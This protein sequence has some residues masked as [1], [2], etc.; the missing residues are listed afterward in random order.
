M[1]SANLGRNRRVTPENYFCAS[2]LEY[3][4]RRYEKFSCF[5]ASPLSHSVMRYQPVA[6]PMRY[7]L[8]V[9]LLGLVRYPKL[10]V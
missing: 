2:S 10:A 6:L 1:M 3:A 9:E 4:V 8:R 7:V 5:S